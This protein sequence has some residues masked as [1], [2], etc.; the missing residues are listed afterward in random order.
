[1]P[2]YEIV[3]HLT[4]ELDCATA[5]DAAALVRR[6]VLAETGAKADVVHLAVWRHDPPPA[7]SLL[8]AQL[9]QQLRE[10]FVALE[11]CASDTEQAFRERVAAILSN[12][13][14]SPN[15]STRG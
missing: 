7:A 1:M 2:R 13:A 10:F 12:P 9:R 3:A 11:R 6:Q 8:P 5:E 15:D 14:Q 4:C